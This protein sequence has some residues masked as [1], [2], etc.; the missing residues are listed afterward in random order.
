M[1]VPCMRTA[2]KLFKDVLYTPLSE[3]LWGIQRNVEHSPFP[4][5]VCDVVQL[6]KQSYL[7][8][9]SSWEAGGR[10]MSVRAG[11]CGIVQAKQGRP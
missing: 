5:E 2:S 10:H 7:Q 8:T 11:L 6:G 1:Y 3:A 9:G 4:G